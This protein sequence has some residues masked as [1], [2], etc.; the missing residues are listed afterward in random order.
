[1]PSSSTPPR[2]PSKRSHKNEL[3]K[4]DPSDLARQLTLYE[5]RL[6]VKIRPHECLTWATAPK[7]DGVKNLRAFVATS[8][9]IA[10]WVKMSVLGNDALGRR[11]D[12]IDLWIKVAEVCC[13]SSLLEWDDM[14]ISLVRN[15]AY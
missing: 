3:L 12:A 14:L 6:Y 10:A 8:D 1:M 13:V 7:G 9:R 11:A 5:A 4:L 2:K 15:A